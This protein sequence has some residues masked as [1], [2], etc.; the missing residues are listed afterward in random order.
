MSHLPRKGQYEIFSHN[1]WTHCFDDPSFDKIRTPDGMFEWIRSQDPTEW[2]PMKSDPEWNAALY[3]TPRLYL[4]WKLK[5][6]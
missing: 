2:H 4:L 6:T 3:L 5:W 1:G